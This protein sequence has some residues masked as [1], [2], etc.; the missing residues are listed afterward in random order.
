MKRSMLFI[1][2]AAILLSSCFLPDNYEL[3][4]DVQKNG[5]YTFTYEGEFN[6]A[7]ALE[8]EIKGEYNDEAEEDLQ[9]IIVELKE[10]EGFESVKDLGKGKIKV[11]VKVEKDA[12]EDYFFLSKDL[13]YFAV[14]HNDDNEMIITG[15]E[16]QDDEKASID[17]FNTRLEGKMT[18]LLPKKMKVSSH[19]ADI[20]E[21]LDKKTMAYTWELDYSSEKPEIIIKL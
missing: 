2:L 5:S 3:T 7:P 18:V 6:Y 1:T 4:I 9:E 20:K 12:D 11:E 16:M 13:E 14:K 15:F 19:N 21:K 8:A 17:E 10:S